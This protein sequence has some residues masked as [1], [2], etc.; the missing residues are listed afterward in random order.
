MHAYMFIEELSLDFNIKESITRSSLLIFRE[1]EFYITPSCSCGG[2]NCIMCVWAISFS[3]LLN[4]FSEFSSSNFCKSVYYCRINI[5]SFAKKL[6]FKLTLELCLS[7]IFIS[8]IIYSCPQWS[9]LDCRHGYSWDLRRYRCMNG[10]RRMSHKSLSWWNRWSSRKSPTKRVLSSS[11]SIEKCLS[12]NA[13]H[14]L[15]VILLVGMDL[16]HKS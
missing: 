11:W 10:H 7:C 5:F 12:K 6:F 3:I 13:S 16:S 1:I 2:S 9:C 4:H 14:S 15:K 8:L